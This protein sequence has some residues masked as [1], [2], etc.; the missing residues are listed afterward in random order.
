MADEQVHFYSEQKI[1]HALSI[2]IILTGLAMLI[3]PL[4]VLAFV[5]DMVARIG[6]MCAFIVVFV[7]LISLTT[8][9]KPFE[10]LAATAA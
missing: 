10:T 4:W 8:V 7:L 3:A 9:A 5:G 1:D 6:I 2:I